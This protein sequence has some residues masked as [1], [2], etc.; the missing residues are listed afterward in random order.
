MKLELK[1]IFLP[2]FFFF[3]LLSYSQFTTIK[4]VVLNQD[5]S[6]L[7]FVNVIDSVSLKGTTTNIKGEFEIQVPLSVVTHLKI[8][9]IGYVDQTLILETKEINT[10]IKVVLEKSDDFL[11]EV[12][13]S[14][15]LTEISKKDSPI[16]VEVYS[17]AYL[18][19]VPSAGLLELTQNIN[20]LRPQLNCAVC[21]TGD[22]H[23]NGMEGPYTMVTIDGMPI[24]GGLS[25]VYGLQGI[26]NSLLQRV[27]VVK[28]PA[29]TLY[30]SEAVA[31]LINV[32]T[33][34]VECAPKFSF[35]I[36]STSWNEI[37]ADAMFTY[38][39]NKKISGIFAVDYHNYSKPIDKN[40]DNF[41]DLTL[42]DRV[43]I[44][45]KW[46]FKRKD[47][48]K[49]ILSARYLYEDRWGGQ[50]NW[51]PSFRGGDSIYGESIYTNRAELIG[52]YELPT[53]EDIVF[54]GSYSFHDQ[55]SRYGDLSYIAEQQIAFGQ[56]VWNKKVGNKHSIVSGLAMSY[57]TYDDNTTAT[58]YIEN[59]KEINRPNSW[60]L[61]GIFS[62]DNIS[63][64][65]TMNLLLGA[66]LDYHSS[67]GPIFSPRMNWKWSPSSWVFRLGYGNGFRVVNIFSEDHAALTGAREVVISD[68]LNP[69]QSNNVNLNIEKQITTQIF[70]LSVDGSLF[71]TYFSNKILPD[72]SVDNQIS[73]SNLNGYGVSRGAT[74]NAKF[75][76][77]FPLT[78]NL[79]FT[80]LDVYAKEYNS[81]GVLAKQ[82]QLFT[83]P[84]SMTWSASYKIQK[85]GL[86]VDYTGNL[87]GPM[88]LPIVENDFRPEY[89][90]PF[91]IMNMKLSKDF[92]Y[93]FNLFLGVRN[94]LNFTPP[95]YSILR[96]NDPFDRL[97]DDPVNNPNNY[98]FDPTYI[99]TSFQGITLFGG[100][101]YVFN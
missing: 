57:N 60:F 28:G 1:L 91:S 71:Y 41:T 39:E 74:V 53:N 43:S 8:S 6:L 24:V 96:A 50:M 32:I 35:N 46:S 40:G 19:K 82:E 2:V 87:Y 7:E 26:P 3:H 4:G 49:A 54:N 42:K 51:N 85:L 23:I 75:L 62:Q 72:Y 44:F 90:N 9:C 27:E 73:Y 37:Q 56:L 101:K 14:G 81:V 89:S 18:N 66:R 84:Y 36:S 45:N 31:G 5:N 93:G 58:S 61:P 77:D 67:H 64:G 10:E 80:L 65:N 94:F 22:I 25:T 34:S 30:G 38:A 52:K 33:K 83:E 48:K 55:D 12:V 76:F 21:N 20:G 17:S 79:G 98:S 69:E 11:D 78:L 15:T 70:K 68:N 47:N 92:K 97:V 95:A 63:I 29:S 86:K 88:K 100:V 59:E 13:I 99:Y 16:P